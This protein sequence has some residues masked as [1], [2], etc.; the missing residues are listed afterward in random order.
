MK[1]SDISSNYQF[2]FVGVYQLD[3]LGKEV[4]IGS[5]MI[6]QQSRDFG[7]FIILMS[8]NQNLEINEKEELQRKLQKFIW[9]FWSIRF[10]E[11]V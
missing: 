3:F 10:W 1:R 6:K 9:D 5:K 7:K 8:K 2:F 4:K 11:W